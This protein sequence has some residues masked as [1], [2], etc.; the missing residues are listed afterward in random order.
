MIQPMVTDAV[1]EV[2]LG[3]SHQVPF[4]PTITF[5][6]GG[7]FTEVFADVA[8]A[9]P[10][11]DAARARTVVESIK[12]I[13]LLRGA[14]GRPRGDVDAL[15]DVV[16]KL[17]KLAVDLGDELSELDINPVMVRPEGRGVVAVDALVIPAAPA[18]AGDI[19]AA[20]ASTG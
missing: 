8:F 15:V 4:G 14:R 12:G 13:K 1:A 5:G 16:M 3:L 6:L 19:P 11:F 10:P 18:P 2:I 17:Q 20:T 9:V 7:V